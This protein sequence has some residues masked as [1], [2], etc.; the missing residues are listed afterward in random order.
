MARK[1]PTGEEV[2]AVIRNRIDELLRLADSSH[3]LRS[4]EDEQR[5]RDKAAELSYVLTRIAQ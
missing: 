4:Y 3:A 5:H 1:K 2:I